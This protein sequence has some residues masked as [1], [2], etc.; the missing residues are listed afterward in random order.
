MGGPAG[1]PPDHVAVGSDD[2]EE[3]FDERNNFR[4]W[5]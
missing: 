4:F 5:L 3:E 2:E 1:L